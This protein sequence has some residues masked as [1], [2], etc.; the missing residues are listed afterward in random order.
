[1]TAGWSAVGSFHHEWSEQ[2]ESN[3]FASYLTLHA[4]LLLA[5]PEAQTLR[6]GI[7]LYWKPKDK[8][9]FGVEFGTVDIKLDLNGVLGFFNGATGLAYIGYLSMSA[10]M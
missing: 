7:N 6:S 9:K 3:V 2:F 5:K 4:D 1:M 10:E 8:L